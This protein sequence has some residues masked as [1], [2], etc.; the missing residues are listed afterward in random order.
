[1]SPRGQNAAEGTQTADQAGP[2]DPSIT[3]LYLGPTPHRSRARSY[4]IHA[5]AMTETGGVFTRRAIVRLTGRGDVPY[6]ILVWSRDTQQL[7]QRPAY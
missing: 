6:R 7:F 1:M 3:I 5:E 2:V 4:T